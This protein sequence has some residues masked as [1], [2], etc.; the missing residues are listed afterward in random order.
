M[1]FDIPICWDCPLPLWPGLLGVAFCFG[2]FAAGLR[3]AR[4]AR[5]G[6]RAAG[7][8]LLVLSLSQYLLLGNYLVLHGFAIADTVTQ[9]VLRM[10]VLIAWFAASGFIVGRRSLSSPHP[11]P[12]PRPS[13]PGLHA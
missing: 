4:S 11:N 5:G 8:L 1:N 3:L 13:V 9:H 12:A 7:V 2:I 10:V 6:V